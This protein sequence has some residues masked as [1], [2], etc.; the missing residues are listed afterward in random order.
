M[1]EREKLEV[2]VVLCLGYL[3]HTYR[4]TELMYRLHHLAPRHLIVD[5]MVVPG[6]K[7]TLRVIR[8][9]DSEDIRQAAQ[10]A[11]SVDRVLVGRPSVP[12]LQMMLRAYGFEI[13]SM[14]DWKGRLAGRQLPG[15]KGYAKGKRATLR[16]RSRAVAKAEGWKPVAP[17]RFHRALI[18]QGARAS[19]EPRRPHHSPPLDGA[20]GSTRR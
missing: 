10:D 12:A 9:R 13:E 7:P 11:Y 18:S 17:L 1:L 19:T 20:G 2:D 4:H 3:Y 8:E 6:T 16:C 5:T 15:L 14:Y